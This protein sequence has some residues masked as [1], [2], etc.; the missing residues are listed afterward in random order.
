PRIANPHKHQPTPLLETARDNTTGRRADFAKWLT[1]DDNALFLRVIANRLW[2]HH[3]VVPLVGTP[4]D[5][6]K[7]GETPT[8]PQL[9][10]W[11]ATELPRRDWSL[12]KMHELMVTSSTYRQ[13]SLKINP[14]DPDNRLLTRMNR[15]R[16]S[17]EAIRDAMLALGGQLNEKTGGPGVHLPLP[18]EVKITLLKKHIK[19][20][21]D[22]NEHRRR[23]IYVFT[24][25]NLRYPT[26]DVF[27]RPD[28]LQSC[29]QRSE[30]TTSTQSLT[31][32]NSA[33]SRAMAEGL[34]KVVREQVSVKDPSAW[35]DVAT[36]RV[37]GRGPTEREYD[38]A[39]AWVREEAGENADRPEALED[40]CLALFNSNAFLYVD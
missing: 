11:L 21:E 22:V 39:Y 38:F 36:W 23:S 2:Q 13:S 34:A 5:F 16:L 1:R 10:D 20:T 17:G 37:F 28:A 4:N 12:K 14:E 24:R 35:V 31:Q 26:F 8:H 18:E 9:L 27:D 7:Q 6:G 40:L 33:F 15:R 3:F 29:A 19:E 30:S 25:R 32:L